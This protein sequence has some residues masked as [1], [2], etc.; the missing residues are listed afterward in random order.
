M[1]ETSEPETERGGPNWGLIFAI[2]VFTL[3]LAGLIY[4]ALPDQDA[5]EPGPERETYG[6]WVF[7]WEPPFWKTLYQRDERVFDIRFRY[8]PQEVENITVQ[9]T[10]ARL[11]SPFYL[12]LDPS[13]SA[14]SK[15]HVGVAFTDATAKLRGIYGETPLPACTRNDTDPTCLT[16]PAVDCGTPNASAI[17]F[18]EA[19]EPSVTL[20]GTCIIIEGT[21][22]DLYRAE[23]LM[24]YR[25]LGIVR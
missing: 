25:L 3:V 12:S 8:L 17:I 10:E 4:L 18:T 14:E 21:G 22:A 24:W 13:M 6:P 11:V 9:G 20:N 7:E 19:P 16:F 5:P 2:G 23:T 15:A 1:S